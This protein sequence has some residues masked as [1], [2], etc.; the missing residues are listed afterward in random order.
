MLNLLH[1]DLTACGA[2][3]GT[4]PSIVKQVVDSINNPLIPYRMKL[5]IAASELVFF[6]SNFRRN[7][8]HWNGSFIPINAIS[9]TISKSGSGK[10]SARN[11]ALK[12]FKEGY[13]LI[14][15]KRK[16]VATA[17]A[18]KQAQSAGKPEPQSFESY[19]EYYR[20]PNP[21]FVAPS[22]SEGFIQHLNDLDTAGIGAGFIYAGEVGSEMATSSV[23]IDNI[24]LLAELAVK[25]EDPELWQ[26][27]NL[28]KDVLR[29][30]S[31]LD[32][33]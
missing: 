6:T 5:T 15:E 13:S 25:A 1:E 26:N 3:S 11:S 31:S 29:Q 24:K 30:K 21:L 33:C 27:P 18:I 2:F 20:S 23:F 28:A 32:L 7:I 16:Q 14:E 17:N 12:C 10:D 4:L 19:H 8:R 22:T 9:F